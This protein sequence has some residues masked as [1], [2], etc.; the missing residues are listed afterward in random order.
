LSRK[1][2]LEI[3]NGDAVQ[4]GSTECLYKIK[5]L[6]LQSDRLPSFED[7]VDDIGCKEGTSKTLL[8]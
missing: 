4:S 3:K 1:C 7:C 5:M 6:E 8:T 2:F